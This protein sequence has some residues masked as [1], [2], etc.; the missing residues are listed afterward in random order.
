MKKAVIL[1]LVVLTL[2][3]T[4]LVGCSP[5]GQPETSSA[6]ASESA[7]AN[8]SDAASS[9]A[10][11]EG[12]GKTLT[13]M[14]SNDWVKD[15]EI[16]L[17]EKF[18]EETGIKVDYQIIPSDQYPNLLTTKLNSGECADIFMHQSGKFDIVSL[19]QIEKNAVDL[20]GEEWVSRFD[21]AVKDQVSA[22][23]K[24]Y[25]VTLWDQGDSYAYIYNKQIFAD[26][27]LN[28]PTSFA[29][30]KQVCQT[31]LDNGITPIYEC[32]ADG[33]HHQLN[34]F[35]VASAYDKSKSGLIDEL[36][37]NKT[38]FA[39]NE[40]FSTMLTQMKEVVDAGYWGEDYMSNEYAD[41]PAALASGEYGMAV[42]MMG[43]VGLITEADPNQSAENFGFFPAPY[44]DNQVIAETPCG[45]SKFIF[46]GSENIDIAKQYLAFLTQPENLQYLIDND[47][48]FNSMPFSGLKSTYSPAITEAMEKYKTGEA[49]VYQNAVIYLNPQWME[50]GSDIT[51]YLLGD[52]TVEDV[53]NGIDTRRADQASA[54]GDTNWQS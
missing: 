42:N 40:A 33:W 35:D 45:P 8:P 49:T 27:G 21:E 20:S 34:F 24:V 14:A 26:L 48:E 53:M 32:V 47:A 17:S 44:L 54:A 3:G 22:N 23:G 11:A 29:E 31:L 30:F 50:I 9:A 39:Q 25:G 12:E 46:S 7:S 19:L 6:A 43:R 51:S 15:A 4:M 36:N 1:L 10:P 18:T 2:V 13:V 37:A 16:A 28:V 5:S 41:L 52:M 38:T